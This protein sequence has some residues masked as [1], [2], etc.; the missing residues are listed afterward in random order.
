[1]LKSRII[2]S[3]TIMAIITAILTQGIIEATFSLIAFSLLFYL[4]RS[5]ITQKING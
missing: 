2:I 4:V 5:R 3:L 1:M